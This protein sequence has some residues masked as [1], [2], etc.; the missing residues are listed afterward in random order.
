MNYMAMQRILLL[1]FNM[2]IIKNITFDSST[3]E[4]IVDGNN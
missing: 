1:D 4:I 2:I 3:A